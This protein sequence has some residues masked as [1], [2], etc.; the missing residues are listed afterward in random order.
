MNLLLFIP[1]C[2]KNVCVSVYMNLCISMHVP[3]C[4]FEYFP[5]LSIAK[6]ISYLFGLIDTGKDL[7]EYFDNIMALSLNSL[8]LLFV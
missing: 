8:V 2:L 3:I 1:T 7:C 5:T 4:I 6:Y